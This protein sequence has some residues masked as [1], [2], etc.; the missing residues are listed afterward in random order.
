MNIKLKSLRNIKTEH[1]FEEVIIILFY[2]YS[3]NIFM[4]LS[5]FSSG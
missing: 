5:S 4:K 3:L 2:C 1:I